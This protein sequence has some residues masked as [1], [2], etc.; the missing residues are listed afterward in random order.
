MSAAHDYPRYHIVECGAE[1]QQL[2][3]AIECAPTARLEPPSTLVPESTRALTVEQHRSGHTGYHH[4]RCGIALSV[5]VSPPATRSPCS[6]FGWVGAVV[7]PSGPNLLQGKPISA[8]RAVCCLQAEKSDAW[9]FIHGQANPVVV[10][11][12][13]ML[14]WQCIVGRPYKLIDSNN[15]LHCQ[16]VVADILDA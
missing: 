13:F 11:D 15:A 6:S 2:E 16:L 14:K 8:T 1:S 9:D 7:Y 3:H 5:S 12:L 10:Q 4:S